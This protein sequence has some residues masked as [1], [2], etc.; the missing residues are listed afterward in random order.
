VAFAQAGVT[1]TSGLLI[2]NLGTADA[3]VTV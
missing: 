1:W 3:S 2:Q